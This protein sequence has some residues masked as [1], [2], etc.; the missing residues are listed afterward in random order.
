MSA[1]LSR[2]R[3]CSVMPCVCASLLREA[4]YRY[5]DVALRLSRDARKCRTAASC[6]YA[7]ALNNGGVLSTMAV[8]CSQPLK[9]GALCSQQWRCDADNN[10][11]VLSGDA[12]GSCRRGI[13]GGVHGQ[14]PVLLSSI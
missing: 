11:G 12:Q 7:R 8:A 6:R 2:V 14:V 9:G 3:H 13:A 4:R 1:I 10:G 5:G